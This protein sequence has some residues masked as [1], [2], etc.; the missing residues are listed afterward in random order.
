MTRFVK[1]LAWILLGLGFVWVAFAGG[2]DCS[3]SDSICSSAFTI[4]LDDF[5]LAGELIWGTAKETA[6][7][8]IGRI[9]QSM[10]ILIWVVA[11]FIMTIGA[12]Y[13]I[14]YHGDEELLSRGKGIFTAGISALVI[15]L[16]AYYIVD[17]V[18]YLLYR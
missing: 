18:G 14:I 7:N 8:V 3:S 16:S 13:M 6:N 9:I 4:Q 1:F 5:W 2:A 15:S 12:G 11:L 10:M 17:L